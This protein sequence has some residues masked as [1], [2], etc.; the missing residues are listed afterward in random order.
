[1]TTDANVKQPMTMEQLK[2]QVA[3]AL[4]SGNDV[5]FLTAIAAVAKQKAE[6]AKA[7]AEQA[8]IENE[9]LAGERTKVAT[10]IQKLVKGLKLDKLIAG[11]KAHGF[12]Y[13]LDEPDANGVM[14]HH[15]S[16][17]M[18]VPTVK[19]KR[20]SIGA[21]STGKSKSE[22]GMSL[23]EIFEKFAT[24]E[25][26]AKLTQATTNSQQWAVKVAVKKQALADGSLKPVA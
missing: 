1:M 25:D 20:T 9:K 14:T 8:R 13:S 19:A 7:Q 18:S 26:R 6:I 16:V 17:S 3:A 24:D 15:G 21:G 23:G 5:D 4:A 12:T 10:E 2:A 11:V 22:Y